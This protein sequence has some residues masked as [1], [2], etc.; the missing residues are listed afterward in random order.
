LIGTVMYVMLRKAPMSADDETQRLLTIKQD[1][2]PQNLSRMVRETFTPI[3]V[4]ET[5]LLILPMLAAGFMFIMYCVQIPTLIGMVSDY[6]YHISLFGMFVG[7][8]ELFGSLISVRLIPMFG[9]VLVSIFSGITAILALLVTYLYLPIVLPTGD[10]TTEVL[11]ELSPTTSLIIALALAFGLSDAGNN[12]TLSIL[13]G[14][15]FAERSEVV[16]SILSAVMNIACCIWF[17]VS[18]YTQLDF[19]I[20]ATALTVLLGM[21]CVFMVVRPK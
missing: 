4:C 3:M 12:T 21:C 2:E 13:I 15:L 14:K 5:L 8:G 10:L 9:Y 1:L 7:V 16:Y 20:V 11:D 18:I 19:I 17:I 6:K